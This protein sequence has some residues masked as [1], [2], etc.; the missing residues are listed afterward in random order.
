MPGEKLVDF[1]DQIAS[2]GRLASLLMESSIHHRIESIMRDRY[3]AFGA[4]ETGLKIVLT[5]IKPGG[6]TNTLQEFEERL[7][8]YQTRG[9]KE[10][11]RGDDIPTGELECRECMAISVPGSDRCTSCG[12]ADLVSASVPR[13]LALTLQIDSGERT[14]EELLDLVW[15]SSTF[16]T[17]DDPE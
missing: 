1:L 15:K 13:S 11:G 10:V 17:T 12:S 8:M 6:K 9:F 2:P 4:G 3:L 5:D 16:L 7:I 14:N